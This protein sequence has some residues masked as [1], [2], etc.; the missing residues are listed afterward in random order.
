MTRVGPNPSRVGAP[1]FL[2]RVAPPNLSR[3]WSRPISPDFEAAQPHRRPTSGTRQ[4]SLAEHMSTGHSLTESPIQK[5][6]DS[7]KARLSPHNS[8]STASQKAHSFFRHLPGQPITESPHKNPPAQPHRKANPKRDRLKQN[9]MHCCLSLSNP[10]RKPG[11][12]QDSLTESLHENPP[13]RVHR[14]PKSEGDR[15]TESRHAV[16]FSFLPGPR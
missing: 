4:D 9:H 2:T 10:H 12:R 13:A 1:A 7:Q 11:T 15:L 5:G 6:P 3:V 16:L 14:K 8:G